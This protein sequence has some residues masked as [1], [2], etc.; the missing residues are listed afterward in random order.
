MADTVPAGVAASP[1]PRPPVRRST[2]SAGKFAILFLAPAVVLLGAL[3][4]YPIGY[5]V[6]RSFFDA[7]GGFNG[8]ANYVDMFTQADTLG[9]ILHNV[10]WV[11]VAP[12]VCTVLGLVFAVLSERVRWKTAFKLIVFMP[13]AISMLAAGVIFRSVFQEDPKVGVANAIA[14]SVHDFF[15]PSSAYP[16]AKPRPGGPLQQDGAAV[17]TKD[18]VQPGTSVDFPLV[19]IAAGTFEKGD[20]TASKAPSAGR[21][22]IT[23]TVWSDFVLGGGGTPNEIGD[24]KNSLRG[25]TVEALPADGSSTK[26]VAT[27]L[28]DDHGRYTLKGLDPGTSYTI[29]LPGSN[30]REAFNGVP[31]L[32]PQLINVVV[33]LSYVWIWAGFCMV[34]VGS[35]LTAIDRSLLEAARTDGANEWQVFRRVTVPQLAPVLVVILVTLVINV[36]KIFDLVYVIPPGSSKPAANVIAVQMWNVSFGGG[37]DQ[38][39]GSAL[40]IF[41]LVLVLPAIILNIRRF[42]SDR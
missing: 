7:K 15:A 6:V 37:N 14:V 35:G 28:T 21:S 25:V 39:L 19:A 33:I 9:S 16:G 3:V 1:S 5:T 10:I 11:L 32:G 12:I 18:G 8:G 22:Q 17:R 36:L 38:G 23:G 29:E 4:V 2:N 40:S 42:R 26:P 24:G 31:W 30:F 27:A 34:M 41:L 20:P 13:M